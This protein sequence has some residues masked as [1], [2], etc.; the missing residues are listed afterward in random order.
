[1]IPV[2]NVETAIVYFRPMYLISTVYAAMM[3]PGTPMIEV[4]A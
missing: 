2:N 3:E 1:M 4:I